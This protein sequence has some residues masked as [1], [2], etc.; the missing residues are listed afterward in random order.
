MTPHYTPTQIAAAVEQASA[1]WDQP[2][3]IVD[4]AARILAGD[5]ATGAAVSRAAEQVWEWMAQAHVEGTE[6]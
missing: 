2:A 1:S 4:T 5:N 3:L 6:R